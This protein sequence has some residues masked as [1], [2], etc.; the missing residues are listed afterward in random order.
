MTK[1]LVK[2]IFCSNPHLGTLYFHLGSCNGL[3]LLESLCP[4]NLFLWS[5][6]IKKIVKLPPSLTP[7]TSNVPKLPSIVGT[8]VGFGFD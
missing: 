5:P 1:L 7:V 4:G 8:A 6:L 3:C 2:G